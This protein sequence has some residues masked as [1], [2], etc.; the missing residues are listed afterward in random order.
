M[1][2]EFLP[3]PPDELLIDPRAAMPVIEPAAAKQL[4]KQRE[5]IDRYTLVPKTSSSMP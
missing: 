4:E 2:F 3:A 5:A 1:S